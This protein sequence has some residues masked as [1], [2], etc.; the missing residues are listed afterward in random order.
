MARQ[1]SV[2]EQERHLEET[3]GTLPPAGEA[4]PSERV[5]VE[6]DVREILEGSEATGGDLPDAVPGM[7]L[8]IAKQREMAVPPAGALPSASEFDAAMKIATQIARTKFVPDSYRGNPDEVL[9]AIF[10]GR[11]LGIGPMQSLRDIHMIDGRPVFA[12]SLMLSQMRRGGLVLLESSSTGDRAFIRAQRS[13][14][15]EIAE[16]DWTFEEA[17]KIKRGTKALTDGDNWKNYPS[18]MLWAR[19]VGR[20][21]RRLGS[22][23]LAGMVYSHEELQDLGYAEIDATAEEVEWEGLDPGAVLHPNAPNGWKDILLVLEYADSAL[24]WPKIIGT[25]LQGKYKVGRVNDLEPGLR[26]VVGRRMANMA[27]YLVDVTM[28]GK[29]FPPP[30]E[31]EV[32]EAIQWAFEG[33]TMEPP[34]PEIVHE[35]EVVEEGGSDAALSAEAQAEMKAAEGDLPEFGPEEA[36]P[37]AEPVEEVADADRAE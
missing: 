14:T 30:N 24:D 26:Q 35:G 37:V 21:A 25:I 7:E 10:T 33:F 17:T 11:E 32:Q 27:G 15:G 6:E 12:A 9:A 31:V 2:E 5:E 36:E 1:R 23:L 34:F 16:V 22:D 13:D 4:P 19:A 29:E 20:L 8:E 28:E 18:D 3:E